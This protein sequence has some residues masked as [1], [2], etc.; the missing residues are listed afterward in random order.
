MWSEA[1]STLDRAERLHRQFFAPPH[2]APGVAPRISPNWEPP[3]DIVE[4][5]G[6]LRIHIALPGVS[7]DSITIVADAHGVTVSA[8]RSFP[9]GKV[10]GD[11]SARIHR[12]EIPYGRFERHVALAADELSLFE[13]TL[14][15]GVLTLSFR[16]KE[17]A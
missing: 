11:P 9:L 3:V 1:L 13:K 5:G 4:E 6:A 17:S 7:P 2:G 15:D 10:C 14:A 16:R 8:L 12:V